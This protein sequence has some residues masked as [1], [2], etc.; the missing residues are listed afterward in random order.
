M[1]YNRSLFD[2]NPFNH[3][4]K[5]YFL[6]FVTIL[7]CLG[8]NHWRVRYSDMVRPCA[9]ANLWR[10]VR[11]RIRS[12]WARRF[13]TL[14]D[15]RASCEFLLAGNTRIWKYLVRAFLFGC[16]LAVC[17]DYGTSF[18]HPRL[19]N[20]GYHEQCFKCRTSRREQGIQ[21]P[22]QIHS[23][24]TIGSEMNSL[25]FFPPFTLPFL[26]RSRSWTNLKEVQVR[27][28]A[29][30]DCFNSWA[31][32]ILDI[33]RA[34]HARSLRPTAMASVSD[35]WL[36]RFDFEFEFILILGDVTLAFF[37]WVDKSVVFFIEIW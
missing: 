3:F 34:P 30:E 25:F 7:K 1:D 17:R 36:S 8:A 19:W 14:G 12:D 9:R 28:Q 26:P 24:K 20:Q 2:I 32:S 29:F 23:F 27:V 11:P 37:S 31:E 18:L 21:F 35:S 33:L 6:I 13:C 4:F 16:G 22:L 15:W 5:C 10:W